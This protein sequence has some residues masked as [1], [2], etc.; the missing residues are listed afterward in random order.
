MRPQQPPADEYDNHYQIKPHFENTP[1][2]TVIPSS[3]KKNFRINPAIKRKIG[4]LYRKHGFDDCPNYGLFWAS[5]P[6]WTMIKDR[7]KMVLLVVEMKEDEIEFWYQLDN[8]V[9]RIRD[10]YGLTGVTVR[11]YKHWAGR[12]EEE[13]NEIE[14]AERIGARERQSRRTRQLEQAAQAAAAPTEAAIQD[15][16]SPLERLQR[17]LED[18]PVPALSRGISDADLPSI[19][20]PG[21]NSP[22]FQPLSPTT[23]GSSSNVGGSRDAEPGAALPLAEVR[24]HMEAVLATTFGIPEIQTVELIDEP[25]SGFTSRSNIATGPTTG[26]GAIQPRSW[27][28][29]AIAEDWSSVFA[30]NPNGREAL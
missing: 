4:E 28:D 2:L 8:E 18:S 7:D 13:S 10:E 19:R 26:P 22:I 17:A 23:E 9:R 14:E 11:Y 5:Y 20:T 24:R 29:E 6:Q 30:Y 12:E 25:P 15:A 27:L 3:S 16:M 1:G 21:S